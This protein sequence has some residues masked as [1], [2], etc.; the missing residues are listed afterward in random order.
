MFALLNQF[1][2]AGSDWNYGL[3]ELTGKVLYSEGRS[4]EQ[5]STLHFTSPRK[6]SV[7]LLVPVSEWYMIYIPHHDKFNWS[8]FIMGRKLHI[9]ASWQLAGGGIVSKYCTRE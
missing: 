6:E 3:F 7:I 9:N 2:S 8:Y 4:L 1:K 5:N